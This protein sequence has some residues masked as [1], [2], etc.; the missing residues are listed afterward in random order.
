M[1]TCLAHDSRARLNKSSS[2]ADFLFGKGKGKG[3][4]CAHLQPQRPHEPCAPMRPCPSCRSI[5]PCPGRFSTI[6]AVFDAFS[7]NWTRMFWPLRWSLRLKKSREG[8]HV[9]V[10]ASLARCVV[11]SLRCVWTG[12]VLVYVDVWLRLFFGPRVSLTNFVNAPQPVPLKA[13][14]PFRL[15]GQVST[16][17]RA[18]PWATAAGERDALV[19][20]CTGCTHRDTG[21]G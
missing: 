20:F 21:G 3:E 16:V 7:S 4:R 14:I 9:S 6:L 5:A 10:F 11:V 15:T 2:S 17:L 12:S 13:R 18:Q 19:S 8:L 1:Q